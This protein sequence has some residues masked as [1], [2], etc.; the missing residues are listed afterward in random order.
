MGNLIVFLFKPCLVL[1]LLGGT[2]P[3]F[4]Q[5]GGVILQSGNPI[6]KTKDTF[7]VCLFLYGR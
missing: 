5:L 2:C 7:I 4:G 1:F 6:I 3:V